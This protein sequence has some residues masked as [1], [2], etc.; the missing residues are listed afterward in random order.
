MAA[1]RREVRWSKAAADDLWSIIE[2]IA[3]DRPLVAQEILGRI[4]QR[5]ASLSLIAHKGRRVPEL[6]R[7]GVSDHRELI[8][9]V[10]RLGETVGRTT[11][12]GLAVIDSRRNLE[13]VLL[14]RL[15]RRG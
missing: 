13:D 14:M 1:R 3:K 2:Y 6:E 5:A 7:Q 10:C 9:F 15:G 12:A 11:V 4:R 8:V